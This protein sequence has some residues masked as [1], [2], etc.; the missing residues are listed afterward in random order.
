MCLPV[1]VVIWFGS[2]EL[3]RVLSLKQ[4]AQLFA[5]SAATRVL[6]T[7]ADFASIEDDTEA[8]A[9]SLGIRGCEVNLSR[10]DS[11]V[12]ESSVVIDFAE[13]S[14][15]SSVLGDRPVTSSY[16]SYREE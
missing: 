14:P 10:V 12:V 2:F 5:S 11:Q 1:L 9:T 4:Q 8:L 6:E 16:Y 13:N 3:S 15:L 7:S